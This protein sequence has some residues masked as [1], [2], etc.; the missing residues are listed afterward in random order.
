LQAERLRV[1]RDPFNVVTVAFKWKMTAH[2]FEPPGVELFLE[3]LRREIVSA[4]QFDVLDSKA[5][6]L[7]EC[8]RDIIS[9]LSS[10]TVKLEADWSLEI[11]TDASRMFARRERHD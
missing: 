7:I 4:G 9:E 2:R 11:R 1:A 6:D 5:A 8:R 10:E 3:F